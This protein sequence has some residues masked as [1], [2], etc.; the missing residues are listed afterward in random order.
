ML[1]ES[2]THR[3][4][5]VVGQPLEEAMNRFKSDPNVRI[6]PSDG[7]ITADIVPGRVTVVYDP[8]SGIVESVE[9]D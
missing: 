3:A 4:F 2:N 8:A 1:P 6:V 7:M 5:D 9:Q